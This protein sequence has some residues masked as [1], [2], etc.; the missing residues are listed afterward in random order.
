MTIEITKPRPKETRPAADPLEGGRELFGAYLLDDES[1]TVASE[2]AKQRGWP[3]DEVV[4]GGLSGALRTLSVAPPPRYMIIDIGPALSYDEVAEGIAEIVRSGAMVIALGERNDVQLYRAIL[5]AGARDYLIKPVD[6]GALNAAFAKIEAPV[7]GEGQA[8]RRIAILGARGGVGASQV[9]NNCAWIMAEELRRKVY[10]ID[11]D[12]QFGTLA[13]L[14]DVQAS[15]GLADALQD[16]ERIDQVFLENAVVRLGKQ[17]HLLASEDSLDAERTDDLKATQTLLEQVSRIADVTL[18]DLPRHLLKRQPGVLGKF[19]DVVLVT[20]ATL[21]GLRDACRLLR[22]LRGRHSDVKVHI[23]VNH[24]EAK[25]EVT[26][27]EIEKG[28]EAP[29][30][31]SLPCARDAMI[32]SEMAGEPLAKAQPKHPV[33]VGLT[34]LT[35]QLAGVREAPKRPMMRRLLK[36]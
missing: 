7:G 2:L 21:V 36:R 28:L 14:L 11:L 29:I 30:D 17:L 23:V 3:T 19:D 22:L 13:L 9:A 1:R 6:L 25:D 31:L 12:L 4:R 33:V 34:R 16:P 20:D 18:V 26:S 32:R 27:K 10:L 35:V 15:G 24:R 5:D 8:G